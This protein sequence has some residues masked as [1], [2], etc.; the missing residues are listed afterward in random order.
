MV[1]IP[2]RGIYL[3]AINRKEANT[4]KKVTML[5]QKIKIKGIRFSYYYFYSCVFNHFN[6][7]FL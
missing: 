7:I 5:P 4:N 6:R 3:K 2:I 1:S